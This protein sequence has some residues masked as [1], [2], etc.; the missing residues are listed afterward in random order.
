MVRY[1]TVM[2]SDD[3]FDEYL[4][5]I[6]KKPAAPTQ[7]PIPEEPVVQQEPST[8]TEMDIDS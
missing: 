5:N 6:G 1:L 3:I 4:N 8:Q 2:F 7:P